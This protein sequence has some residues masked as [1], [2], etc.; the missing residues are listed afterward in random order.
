MTKLQVT[1]NFYGFVVIT[2]YAYDI[3]WC[4]GFC[5]NQQKEREKPGKCDDV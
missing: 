5:M 1:D 3:K 2:R 4:I